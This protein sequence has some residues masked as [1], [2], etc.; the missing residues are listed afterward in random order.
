MLS[1]PAFQLADFFIR[2]SN[3]FSS[4]FF[5]NNFFVATSP[6]FKSAIS[7]VI[8]WQKIS[9]EICECCVLISISRNWIAWTLRSWTESSMVLRAHNRHFLIRW[10]SNDHPWI[11]F[12]FSV[13][14]YKLIVTRKCTQRKLIATQARKYAVIQRYSFALSLCMRIKQITEII[15]W[16]KSHFYR[17]WFHVY[18]VYTTPAF[19]SGRERS[20]ACTF[21]HTRDLD[22]ECK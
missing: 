8:T 18:C 6:D 19:V 20:S 16:N 9:Y 13:F 10:S 15:A 21:V 11:K 5:H 1:A 4:Y 3:C 14:T 7:V 2:A 12:R 22:Q 17:Q